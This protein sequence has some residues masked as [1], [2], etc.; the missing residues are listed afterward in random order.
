MEAEFHAG[1]DPQMRRMTKELVLPFLPP[2]VPERRDVEMN[3]QQKRAYETM[4]DLMIAR[5]D[6]GVLL[7]ANPMVQVARLL[8]L[9]SSYGDLRIIKVKVMDKETG[10][11][12]IDP[13]T[14]EPMWRDEEHLVPVEP[15]LQA[16]RVHQRPGRLR[17]PVRH[18]LRRVPAADRDAL[19]ADAQEG[20]SEHGLITGKIDEETRDRTIEDFQK[21]EFQYVLCTIKAGGVGITL[22][23]ASV[24]LFIQRSWSPIEMSQA[25]ARGHRIG[26]EIHDS[27][28]VVDYVCPRH[29]RDDAD[30]RA[31]PQGRH[32]RRDRPRR[33]PDAEAAG[34]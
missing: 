28:T 15:L 32:A 5:L 19:G 10:K 18:R 6:A 11:Q 25:I 3:P 33:G 9:A 20:R 12:K 16:G 7:A 8:Q 34:G 1:V 14:G 27:I 26:S 17:R 22:T 31:G 4:R 29:R 21:G 2:I 13:E 23:K 30:R 24:E